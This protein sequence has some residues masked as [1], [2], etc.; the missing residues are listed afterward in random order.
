VRCAAET[1]R[2]EAAGGATFELTD[3]DAPDLAERRERLDGIPFAKEFAA[4]RV[5]VPGIAGLV[6]H[7]E[8]QLSILSRAKPG[9]MER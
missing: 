3:N 6:A 7:L 9:M 4:A 8:D 2:H 1:M 5:D